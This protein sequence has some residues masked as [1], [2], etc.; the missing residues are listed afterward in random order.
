MDEF[1][2][3]GDKGYLNLY[4]DKIE[5]INI[6]EEDIERAYNKFKEEDFLIKYGFLQAD[7]GTNRYNEAE[8][9]ALIVVMFQH[10]F[11]TPYYFKNKNGVSAS[12]RT[13]G[14]KYRTLDTRSTSILDN[15]I[16]DQI[17]H[18]HGD[19]EYYKEY[20][21]NLCIVWSAPSLYYANQTLLD[22]DIISN[23]LYK[24]FHAIKI[25][26][27]ILSNIKGNKK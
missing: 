6:K 10:L 19:K 27:R 9:L 26:Y 14:L 22:I 12:Q 17:I 11:L 13:I 18:D 3:F 24:I 7:S 1:G 15:S 20:Y 23:H 25:I 16:I 4:K 5:Q 21:E 2:C 8:I